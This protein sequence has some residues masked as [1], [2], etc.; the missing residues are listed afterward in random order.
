MFIITSGKSSKNH[1]CTWNAI[2]WIFKGFLRLDDLRVLR[3][4]TIGIQ[5]LRWG[6]LH[7]TSKTLPSSPKFKG[8]I[9]CSS[10]NSLFARHKRGFI[11]VVYPARG[12]PVKRGVHCKGI[13]TLRFYPRSVVKSKTMRKVVVPLYPVYP[14]P[15]LALVFATFIKIFSDLR[16]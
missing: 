8:V 5:L 3:F 15:R 2:V 10:R 14:P 16:Q 11:L 6:K 12:F 13:Y 7:S 4:S 9:L 1:I